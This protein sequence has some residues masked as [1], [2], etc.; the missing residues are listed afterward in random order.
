MPKSIVVLLEL[1]LGTFGSRSQCYPTT[2][3]RITTQ[4]SYAFIVISIDYC[5]R[6]YAQQIILII[7]AHCPGNNFYLD[8]NATRYA[9]TA[10]MTY[11]EFPSQF[12]VLANG[13][14]HSTSQTFK[15]SSFSSTYILSGRQICIFLH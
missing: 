11:T 3:T 12:K 1:E 4:Y 2:P 5:I 14:Y 13:Q 7:I 15:Y 10:K 8:L 9:T 6:G